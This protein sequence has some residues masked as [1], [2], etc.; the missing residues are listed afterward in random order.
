VA[1][2]GGLRTP[3]GGSALSGAK[4]LGW[5]GA[6]IKARADTG[7]AIRRGRTGRGLGKAGEGKGVGAEGDGTAGAEAG[8]D[9]AGTLE[10]IVADGAG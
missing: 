9:D 10:G 3:C 6:T 7:E 2:N 8:E 1:R 5:S 4:S